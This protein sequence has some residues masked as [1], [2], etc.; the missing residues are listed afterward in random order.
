MR[1][2]I[3]SQLKYID[4]F[5]KEIKKSKEKK[6]LYDLDKNDK[7]FCINFYDSKIYNMDYVKINFHK[8]DKEDQN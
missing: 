3:N 4:E 5:K 1:D 7:I 2:E 6:S 8:Q